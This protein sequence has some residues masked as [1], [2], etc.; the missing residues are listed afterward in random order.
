MSA[1]TAREAALTMY[2]VMDGQT[3]RENGASRASV[4]SICRYWSTESFDQLDGEAIVALRFCLERAADLLGETASWADVAEEA[5]GVMKVAADVAAKK[6]ADDI[7]ARILDSAQDYLEE[8]LRFNIA[9]TLATAERERKEAHDRVAGLNA[10]ADALRCL[11]SD[12]RAA[13]RD[14]SLLAAEEADRADLMRGLLLRAREY[15]TDALDAYE[16]SDGRELLGA[17]DSSLTNVAAP[18]AHAA[19]V[20]GEGSR[21]D[22]PSSLP[23][24]RGGAE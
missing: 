23:Q 5:L 15:V 7:Y 18:A 2:G 21:D 3:T 17:I 9:S 6:A 12:E 10:Q 22:P 13:R 16:H 24:Q 4:A 11:L 20:E 19:Q 1:T 8:N 14:L